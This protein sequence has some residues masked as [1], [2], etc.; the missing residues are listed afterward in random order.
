ML[1]SEEELCEGSDQSMRQTHVLSCLSRSPEPNSERRFE[2]SM[3]RPSIIAPL[4]ST[5]NTA[6]REKAAAVEPACSLA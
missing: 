1:V 6:A 2:H 4:A 5:A 3:L